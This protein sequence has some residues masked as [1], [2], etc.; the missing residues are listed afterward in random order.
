VPVSILHHPN[1]SRQIKLKFAQK[2]ALLFGSLLGNHISHPNKTTDKF[3]VSIF[4]ALLYD[5]DIMVLF[6]NTKT[7][8]VG[9]FLRKGIC[10]VNT[11]SK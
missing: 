8:L 10:T 1:N 3:I 11:N 9:V 5:S 2:A 7:T 6:Y 4:Q